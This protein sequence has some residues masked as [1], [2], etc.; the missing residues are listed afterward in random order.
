MK[1]NSKPIVGLKGIVFIIAAFF[2]FYETSNALELNAAQEREQKDPLEELK[3]VSLEFVEAQKYG[4]GEI[5][6]WNIRNIGKRNIESIIFS[7][8]YHLPDEE[9][10]VDIDITKKIPPGG[11]KQV[12]FFIDELPNDHH[13]VIVAFGKVKF[14]K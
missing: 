10:S 11:I 3:S 13:G 6:V 5:Q 4:D 1:R 2:L 7:Y 9:I 12:S 8:F 14:S